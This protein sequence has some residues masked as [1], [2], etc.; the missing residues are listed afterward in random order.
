MVNSG[1]PERMALASLGLLVNGS[2]TL[3]HLDPPRE[4]RKGFLV[5][6]FMPMSDGDGKT[7]L[8]FWQHM[9]AG[10]LTGIIEHSAMFP[11]DTVKIHVQMTP[12]SNSSPCSRALSGAVR[13][14]LK[15]DGP[16][17]FYRGLGAVAIGAGPSHA[18]HFAVYELVRDR[19]GGNEDEHRRRHHRVAADMAAGAA[20]TI[21][22]DALHTPMD[23]VTWRRVR[24]E[25]LP[26]Q[27]FLAFY[28]S[29]GPFSAVQFATYAAVKRRMLDAGEHRR[30]RWPGVCGAAKYGTNSIAAVAQHIV[31]KEGW[32]ALFKEVVPRVLLHGRLT[33]LGRRFYVLWTRPRA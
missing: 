17:G 14:I 29:Y 33:R 32:A 20:A 19:L 13:S 8:A 24:L 5:P 30:G 2:L 23:V 18:L 27:G 6:R 4:R 26:Y 15:S 12:S 28:A 31:A 22:G 9:V 11:V 1:E 7:R 10:S 21:A 16:A 25:D 3:D